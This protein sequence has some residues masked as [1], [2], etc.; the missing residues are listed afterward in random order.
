MDNCD[1][2]CR[3]CHDYFGRNPFTFAEWLNF[4][5]GSIAELEARSRI[6][7]DRDYPAIIAALQA[8]LAALKSQGTTGEERVNEVG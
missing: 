4:R 7:W 1:F 6:P 2:L 8:Q 3:P 5:V